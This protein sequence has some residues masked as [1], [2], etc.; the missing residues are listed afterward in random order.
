MTVKTKTNFQIERTTLDNGLRVVVSPDRSSPTITVV[1]AYDVGF[2]SEPEG[3]TGFAHLFEHLMFQG[4]ANLPKGE[5]DRLIEGNGG[6]INGFTR[7]DTTVYYEALPSNALEVALFCEADR[8]F[9]I[10]LTEENLKNQVD[11]VKEEIRVNVHNRAY[12]G[13]PW[14][15]LPAIMFDTFPNAHDGYGSFVDL[16][17]ATVDDAAAFF[18]RYYSPGN[19]VLAIGGDVDPGEALAQAESFFARVPARDVPSL[20]DFSEPVPSKERRGRQVDPNA[21]VPAIAL[22]YRV[23][24]AFERFEDFLASVLLASVL[25]DG[26]ASRLYER[27]VKKERAAS[28]IGSYV[29]T[30]NGWLTTRD[31]MMFE[32]VAY[33]PDIS[34]ADR[35]VSL[36]DEEV[37]RVSTDLDDDELGRVKAGLVSDFLAESDQLTER[38][39]NIAILEQQRSRAELINE[40]PDLLANVTAERV[41]AV[42]KEWLK[43][44]ARA[45]LDWIPA[46]A[47]APKAAKLSATKG[48]KK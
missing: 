23:P 25:G 8:M 12:G 29:S 27:L 3:R 22:G 2:R 32:T 44:N 11:V 9:E 1:V 45:R 6:A 40:I 33:I 5:H 13:F 37:E 18:E 41:S 10:A 7:Y 43:P 15:H 16:E 30:F 42:A 34:G 28:H 47:V 14:L 20:D 48:K 31:P 35:A 19:A 21:P 39:V 24:H 17:A 26:S 46:S 4:S 38:V 36:I